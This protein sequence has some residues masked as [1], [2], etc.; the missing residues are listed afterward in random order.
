MKFAWHHLLKSTLGALLMVA[1]GYAVALKTGNYHP[2]RLMTLFLAAIC[3][4]MFFF[5]RGT[6]K[7]REWLV[8]IA[9]WTLFPLLFGLCG[10][11]LTFVLVGAFLS[12]C[13]HM[14]ITVLEMRG[15]IKE[16]E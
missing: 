11:S 7:K 4:Q 12:A 15:F 1:A 14:A 6:F 8:M 10:L 9:N 3:F 16:W 5:S 2:Y 13:I